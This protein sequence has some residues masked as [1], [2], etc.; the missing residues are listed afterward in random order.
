MEVVLAV[1]MA[2]LEAVPEKPAEQVVA[3]E[4]P[5]LLLHL[6]AIMVKQQLLMEVEVVEQVKQEGLAQQQTEEMAQHPQ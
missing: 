3:L 6:K 1:V 2:V 5:R 4:T